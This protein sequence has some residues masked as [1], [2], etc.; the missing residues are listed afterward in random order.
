MESRAFG[1]FIKL[2]GACCWVV[3]GRRQGV[4][5]FFQREEWALYNVK[6]RERGHQVGEHGKDKAEIQ[7]GDADSETGTICW[8]ALLPPGVHPQYLIPS[9]G[10][11][12][13]LSKKLKN[14][15]NSTNKA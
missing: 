11:E 15:K 12:N 2:T 14:K 6:C 13:V 4:P 8:P 5:F 1:W 3:G 7:P 10:E 9:E